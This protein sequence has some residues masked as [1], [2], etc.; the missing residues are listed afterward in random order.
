[1]W[2]AWRYRAPC[3]VLQTGRGTYTIGTPEVNSIATPP[4]PPIESAL[5]IPPTNNIFN[6]DGNNVRVIEKDGEPWF[7]AKD[8]AEV[9]GYVNT[10]KAV[11]KHCKAIAE[12]PIWDGRQNRSMQIIPERDIYRLVLKS[13]LPAAEKFEEWVVGEV[14]P[15]IRKTGKYSTDPMTALS[16]PSTKAP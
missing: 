2:L 12:I 1:M 16:D 6:F 9:L 14:L 15:T 13:N 10:A 7:V 11:T 5:T 4:T 3:N 8:V